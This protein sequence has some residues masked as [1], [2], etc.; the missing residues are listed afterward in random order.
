MKFRNFDPASMQF[1]LRAGSIEGH[2]PATAL[3]A[4][5]IRSLEG[6]GL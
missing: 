6:V 3:M 2:D 4:S 5:L 1:E